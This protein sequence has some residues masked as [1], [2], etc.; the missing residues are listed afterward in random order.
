MASEEAASVLAPLAKRQISAKSPASFLRIKMKKT[1]PTLSD[2]PKGLATQLEQHRFAFANC[3]RRLDLNHLR[4]ET[5]AL[6]QAAMRPPEIRSSDL[7]LASGT[8]GAS[9]GEVVSGCSMS[10]EPKN[11]N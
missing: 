7:A 3:L 6:T 10:S 8:Y 1:K 9:L 4:V 11:V 5:L 2:L